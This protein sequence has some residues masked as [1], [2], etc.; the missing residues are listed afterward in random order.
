[1]ELLQAIQTR[2][3]VRL[4]EATTIPV[5]TIEEIVRLAA[6]APSACDRQGWRCILLQDRKDLEWLY[7]RG[8]SSVFKTS[9]QAII[10]C[11]ERQTENSEW[12]DNIQSAAAFIAYFQLIAHERGIGSCWVCHLP[13]RSEVAEHFSIPS[14]Y[15]PVA[16]VT[17][18]Y[19]KAGYLP[20]K[21]VDKSE[22]R[23]LS[24]DRWE[25]GGDRDGSCKTGYWLRKLLREIYYAL[26]CR[27][28]LRGLAGRY[29]KKFDE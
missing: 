3:S 1:M 8:G 14:T 5:E 21:R 26:P 20:K 4:Y 2:R 18:G 23:L 12:D 19:N 22:A 17:L 10:V 7:S 16:V 28:W 27:V 9:S 29:E 6:D 13:P 24:L 11:Y 15:L 25:F